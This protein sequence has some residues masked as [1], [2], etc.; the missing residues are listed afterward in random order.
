MQARFVTMGSPG[1]RWLLAGLLA[2]A[3]PALA[4]GADPPAKVVPVPALPA[5]AGPAPAVRRPEARL[6]TLRAERELTY[7][8]V[9]AEPEQ[10]S[11]L[12]RFLHWLA[13]QIAHFRS[14]PGGNITWN[15]I[16]YGLALGI[17]VFAVLK[18]LQLD[19]ARLFG[20][21]S[22]AGG[23]LGYEVGTENIHELDFGSA[24]SEAES[25][26][27]LRL[28]TR[29]GYL[30]LLKQLTDQGLIDWQPDKTN[31]AYLR[32]LATAGPALN[33][34]FTELTRQFEYV[35]YGEF[36]LSA[37]AYRPLRDGQ[38]AFGRAILLVTR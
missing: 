28:A 38:Q 11:L 5:P 36:P 8:E 20:R 7:R 14:T 23:A 3:A 27:N 25:A 1:Q 13:R 24:L 15:T 37:A 29:L 16:F 4:L 35:W 12:V 22:K 26:G 17:L 34:Q 21:S 33:P 30:H 31:Q 9:E 18:F 32:E 2:L 6:R 19:V 10:E